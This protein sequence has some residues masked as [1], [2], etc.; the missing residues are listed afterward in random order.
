M[1]GERM[2]PVAGRMGPICAP[3]E[4]VNKPLNVSLD[5]NGESGGCSRRD[6]ICDGDQG[7]STEPPTRF[8]EWE[9]S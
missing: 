6:K 5:E 7:V 3:S 2:P 9:P 8:R 4:I 1:P